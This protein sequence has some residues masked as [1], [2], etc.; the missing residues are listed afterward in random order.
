MGRDLGQCED[1]S[2]QFSLTHQWSGSVL[3]AFK[4]TERIHQLDKVLCKRQA[5]QDFQSGGIGRHDSPL[6]S[7]ASK[8]TKIENN[9]HSEPSEIEL[10]GSLTTKELNHIHSDWKEGHR[11]GMGWSHIHMWW[12]KIWEGYLGNKESQ[13]HTRTPSQG[14]S[15]RKISPHNF[16]LQK[17]VGIESL[18]ETSGAPSSSF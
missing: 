12:I 8:T 13:P 4:V 6:H 10:N 7:T 17:P 16:W 2:L 15:A 18:E 1:Q 9:H 11:R 5:A 3:R 14:S